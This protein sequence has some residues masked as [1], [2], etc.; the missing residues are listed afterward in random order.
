MEAFF[1]RPLAVAGHNRKFV[2]A[3]QYAIPRNGHVLPRNSKAASQ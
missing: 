2:V 3:I 1:E